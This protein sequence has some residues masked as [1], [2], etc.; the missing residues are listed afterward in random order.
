VKELLKQRLV[1]AI[2]LIALAVIFVPMIFEVPDESGRLF[3]DA[4]PTQPDHE[5]PE[6]IRPIELPPVPD[7]V[8]E[9]VQI[10]E[11]A[12]DE[13]IAAIEGAPPPPVV[14]EVEPQPEISNDKPEKAASDAHEADNAQATRKAKGPDRAMA[15][16]VVQV[17]SVKSKDNALAL[18]DKLRRLGFASFVEQVNASNGTLY[19]VRV[20]PEITRSGAEK[21]LAALG[22]KIGLKA[23]ILQYP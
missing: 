23:I 7:P 21:Q 22:E 12:P 8:P 19:R 1:G 10:E 14:Q 13:A 6:R 9:V 16:W 5:T 15:G 4:L 3:G 2:V 18:K 20:G 11:A 17:A